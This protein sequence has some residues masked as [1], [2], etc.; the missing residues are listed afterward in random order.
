V[1]FIGITPEQGEPVAVQLKRAD[2]R[3]IYIREGTKQRFGEETKAA[4]DTIEGQYYL[5]R[6][7]IEQQALRHS[8]VIW[9]EDD[10]RIYRV[11][12]A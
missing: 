4:P 12:S 9:H 1:P 6:L 3:Y 8:T 10:C 7:P 5:A 11:N 2:M